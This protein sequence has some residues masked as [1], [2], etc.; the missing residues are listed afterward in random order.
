MEHCTLKEIF[1]LIQNYLILVLRFPLSSLS[2]FCV[3]KLSK[4]FDIF[5]NA[6]HQQV[7]LS[8]I[9]YF[10]P[11]ETFNVKLKIILHF[12]WTYVLSNKNCGQIK[13]FCSTNSTRTSVYSFD[14]GK[15]H[16]F[17]LT[18]LVNLSG[19]LYSTK[20]HWSFDIKTSWSWA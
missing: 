8:F 6:F 10:S 16:P 9:F 19:L 5:M 4:L 2:G 1:T 18:N 12:Q 11:S 7:S 20:A 14:V 15:L 17:C 13:D 3:W